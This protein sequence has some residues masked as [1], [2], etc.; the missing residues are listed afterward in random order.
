[1]K[2][3]KNENKVFKIF[4]GEIE[5]WTVSKGDS[6]SKKLRGIASG[7]ALD[8]EGDR[9]S[10]DA[11]RSM[12][13]QIVGL[14]LHKDHVFNVD[15]TIG[16]FV[17]AKILSSDDGD[18]KEL[19]VEAELEPFDVNPDAERIFEKIKS[20]TR[21]AFSVAGILKGW[22]KIDSKDGFERFLIT[23]IEL[24]S[25]DLV[26][27]PAYR[28]SQGSLSAFQAS[29]GVS[30]KSTPAVYVCKQIGRIIRGTDLSSRSNQ[31]YS[32]NE[33]ESQLAILERKFIKLE[34]IL[35]KILEESNTDVSD[36]IERIE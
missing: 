11:L 8:A 34:E 24:L 3:Q 17:D 23:D 33:N 16:H 29:D 28:A 19:W 5:A 27:I 2:N 30:G 22:E 13:N 15:N 20:G 6:Q 12:E 14:T 10:E 35:T 7:T 31:E 1:M 21:L 18:V 4:T 36:L 32:Q 9:M 25:V 26:T